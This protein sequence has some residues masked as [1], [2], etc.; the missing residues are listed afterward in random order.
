MSRPI[1]SLPAPRQSSGLCSGRNA[2]V[3]MLTMCSSTSARPPPGQATRRR[4]PPGCDSIPAAG[5]GPS[6]RFAPSA[7]T[8]EFATPRS[9]PPDG[10][11][12]TLADPCREVARHASR[13]LNPLLSRRAP[14]LFRLRPEH[15]WKEFREQFRPILADVCRFERCLAPLLRICPISTPSW[16]D[17]G[18]I[19]DRSGQV[20]KI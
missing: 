5:V 16:F 20:A 17:L 10:S 7:S 2:M 1:P 14:K 18:Q 13:K 6:L 15:A 8:A 9:R 12:R 4:P 11:E 19:L 3:C